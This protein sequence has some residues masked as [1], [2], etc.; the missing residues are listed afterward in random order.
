M[1]SYSTRSILATSRI[2]ATR[3]DSNDENHTLK[4]HY[5]THWYWCLAM[6]PER[7]LACR[8]YMPAEDFTISGNKEL[9]NEEIEKPRE[10]RKQNKGI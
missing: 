1:H 8:L 3:R 9:N 7:S 6:L 10:Q 5:S 2:L 4:Q